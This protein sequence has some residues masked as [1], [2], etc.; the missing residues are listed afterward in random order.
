MLKY[1]NEAEKRNINVYSAKLVFE[2]SC[3]YSFH[4]IFL[5]AWDTKRLVPTI[6]QNFEQEI[7][8]L[9][10]MTVP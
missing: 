9:Y 8:L 4:T 3:T 6:N 10:I 7:H 2:S 5:Q 1:W